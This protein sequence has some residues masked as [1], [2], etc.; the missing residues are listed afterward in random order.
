MSDHSW[1]FVTSGLFLVWWI[2][3]TWENS[4]HLARPPLVSPRNDVLETS[5][6]IPYWWRVSTQIWVVF[7]IGWS[8]FPAQHVQSETLP[9]SGQWHVI[10]MECLHLF[11]RRHFAGNLVVGSRNV[12]YFSQDRLLLAFHKTLVSCHK[13]SFFLSLSDH[14]IFSLLIF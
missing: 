4:W 8:E 10:S 7:L 13:F 9:R 12:G 6:E 11:L 1:V 3:L 5:A 2:K 14:C